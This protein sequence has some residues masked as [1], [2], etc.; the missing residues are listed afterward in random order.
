MQHIPVMLKESLQ[1]FEGKR[2]SSFFDATVGAGGF[3][4]AL[5]ETHPEIEVYYG[6]DRDENAL[7][8][9]MENLKQF[10]K[11]VVLIHSNFS[12]LKEVLNERG[13][14][15]VDGFFLI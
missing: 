4:K 9:A 7:K 15:E 6:C 1:V 2:L 12:D 8:I 10:E 5:L 11:K 14:T 3:G 13:V